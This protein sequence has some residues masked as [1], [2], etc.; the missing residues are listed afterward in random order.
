MPEH[1]FK[2]L[3]LYVGYRSK[4]NRI[5]RGMPVA[6]KQYAT[7]W[8]DQHHQVFELSSIWAVYTVY[9]IVDGANVRILLFIELYVA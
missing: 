9:A 8:H 3:K 1:W 7:L 6:L 4:K 5:V 2:I